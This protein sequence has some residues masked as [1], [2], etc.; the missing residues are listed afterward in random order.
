MP[1]NVNP[2]PAD[3]PNAGE[4]SPVK[5]ALIEIRHLRA[6]L[7]K[8]KRGI[9]EPVAIVGMAM[10]F[11]GGVTTPERFW[12]ALAE[13]EDLIGTVPAERWDARE[14]LN[15]DPDHAGT[16]YDGHGGFL[17]DIDA[18][19]AEFFGINPREAASM[20]PQQRMLLELTWEALERA[21]IDPKALFNSA[22]GVFL[23]LSNCDYARYTM[24]DPR[25][26][27]AYA[28][29]GCTLSIAA[30]RISYFLGTHGPALIVD[31]ACSSSL[32]A[33][34]LAMQ[35]LR[36]GEID[37]AIVGAANLILTPEYSVSFSRTRMLSPHGRSKT[38]DASADGYVRSEGCG[39]VILRRLADAKRDG[40]PVLA[41]IVGVAVNQDGRS[42]G[43]TAPNGPAQEAVI[44]AALDDA[45]VAPTAV[46]F[47]ETHG[48]GTPL[49]DPM[50]VQALSAVYGTERDGGTPLHIGSVKTNLGHAEAAAGMAGLMKVV[51]TMQPGH[52]ITPHLHFKEPNQKIDWKN[53]PIKVPTA[54]TP[55]PQTDSGTRYA[56]LSSFGFSG[57]NAHMIIASA[58]DDA[59]AA[60]VK[61]DGG[62]VESVLVISASHPESL[63]KQAES[64][65]AF[66]QK[67]RERFSDICFTAVSGRASLEHRLALRARDPRSAASMLEQWLAGKSVAGLVSKESAPEVVKD[68]IMPLLA[69]YIQGEVLSWEDLHAAG[70]QRRVALPVYPFR[71][72]RYWFG[73]DPQKKQQ[74]DRERIW[75]SAVAAAELQSRQGPLGWDP[76]SYAERWSTLHRLTLAHAQSVLAD[77]GA[78]RQQQVVSADDVLSQCGFQPLYRRLVQRW[79]KGLVSS[80]VLVAEGDCFRAPAA[81]GA[82]SF[83]T[84]WSATEQQLWNN[85]GLLAY[86]RQ[87]SALLGDV[88]TGRKSSLETLFPQGSFSIAEG[89]YETGPEAR[90]LNPIAA[91]AVN[92]VA[93]GLGQRRNARILEIGGGTG[94]TTSAILP[95]LP[96]GQA[97]YWFTDVSELFL[98]RAQRRFGAYPFVRYALFDLDRPLEEQGIGAGQFDVIVAANVIHAS[99]NLNLALERVRRL[100]APGGMLVL[101]ECTTH[102]SHFDMSV[103]LIEGWQHF[104]DD[105]RQEHPLLDIEQWRNLLEA[106]GFSS[107][108]ALPELDSP[109]SAVGQHIL[110]ARSPEAGQVDS[111]A[112]SQNFVADVAASRSSEPMQPISIDGRGV[113]DRLRTLSPNEREQAVLDLVRTT[114]KR[115]FNLPQR[116]E[117][118]TPRDRLSDL[119]MDSLIALELRAELAKVFGLEAQI[120]STIAFDTGTV[121]ELAKALLRVVE[122]PGHE[123][124]QSSEAEVQSQNLPSVA[125]VTL[126]ELAEMSD[127]DVERLL[128]ERLSRR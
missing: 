110:I 86:L 121:G 68:P 82:A 122:S 128:S 20:D 95:M 45:Q 14:Y 71:K 85:P 80:G 72:T 103:G 33:L 104:E 118:L 23:G 6:E 40:D 18:F 108:I 22:A 8:S 94:G 30:G 58:D 119:G 93:R 52:G 66:L 1:Q 111:D 89:L 62:D 67:T 60:D 16:M 11:P 46:S 2:L 4:L 109:A 55:W 7:E 73:P 38:F 76:G 17:A 21:A 61:A 48:T 27:D 53:L 124:M 99:R 25:E 81:F 19:D 29:V 96:A 54:L 97:E 115:V 26:I 13:G 70:E 51:L 59:P 127:E 49:G 69:R 10:R 12:E 114:I 44:R 75:Q 50:E 64:Y 42:A 47:V 125:Q 83:E 34:D 112:T 78:F 123:E 37:L 43:I 3:M 98:N 87:C 90:F 88:L 32:V 28:S 5:R 100:L 117:E 9:H 101:L 106:N 92:Q 65:A 15:T 63:R 84:H 35:S 41:K 91:A 105:I 77:A 113:T 120:S 102:H 36:R 24:R 116:A 79:L 74:M 39:V 107:M 31:T 56:G 57:T 126:D